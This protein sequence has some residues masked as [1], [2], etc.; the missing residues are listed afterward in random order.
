MV[1]VFSVACTKV[2]CMMSQKW[3]IFVWNLE[4]LQWSSAHSWS[5]QPIWEDWQFCE[6]AT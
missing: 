6:K 2:A 4:Y 5:G 1:H 3:N